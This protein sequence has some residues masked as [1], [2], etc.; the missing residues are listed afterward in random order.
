M[1]TG[2][3]KHLHALYPAAN[4]R[5]AYIEGYEHPGDFPEDWQYKTFSAEGDA[6]RAGQRQRGED[7][8]DE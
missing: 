6:F 7:G 1:T 5:H 3:A 2:Y 4:L 8:S